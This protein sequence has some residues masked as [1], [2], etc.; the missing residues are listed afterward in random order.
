M[1]YDS[2]SNL[3]PDLARQAAEKAAGETLGHNS[4]TGFIVGFEATA[5]GSRLIIASD[6]MDLAQKQAFEAS[7]LA[8]MAQVP[9]NGL[10]PASSAEMASMPRIYFKRLQGGP[11]K[12]SR[13]ISAFGI[14]PSPRAI[15]GVKRIIA[16][17]SG[18][19]GVGKSTVSANLAVGLAR[20][21]RKVGL[22]DADFYGPSVPLL[23]GQS[24]PLEVTKDNKLVPRMSLGVKLMSF[25]FLAGI[26]EP[27]IWR[28]PLVAKALQQFCYEVEWGDL[29]DLVIDLP[30]GTGDVQITMIE[31]LPLAGAIVVS[32]PQNIA[33]ADAYKAVA[34]FEKLKIP[35]FGIVENMAGY[36]C[37][38]CGHEELI[39][40]ESGV[41]DLAIRHRLEVL[42][43]LPL[44]VKVRESG[45]RGSPIAFQD[46]EIVAQAFME[47]ATK[48]AARIPSPREPAR[49]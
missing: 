14:T 48:V 35:M 21:G 7:Y 34:M 29:D 15:P 32:T 4:D 46:G 37:S 16:I 27:L 2:S 36:V 49:F 9:Q 22:L 18:K 39:F 3:V 30:P 38:A 47:I 19:G 12:T 11:K 43:R 42:G 31:Q 28:G 41:D 24:G 1:V 13:Q 6:G 10:N 5:D 44:Q 8:A 25:G 17:G 26:N 33:L 40:G 20:L 23:F 45:D